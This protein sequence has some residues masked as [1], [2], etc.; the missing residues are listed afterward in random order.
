[1][2]WMNRVHMSFW[3]CSGHSWTRWPM[4]FLNWNMVDFN[5]LMSRI[6]KTIETNSYEKSFEI[7]RYLG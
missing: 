2:S 5:K 6:L 3:Q 7:G 4:F 1:M